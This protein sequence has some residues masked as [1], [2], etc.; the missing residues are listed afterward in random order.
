MQNKL[1]DRGTQSDKLHTHTKKKNT[2]KTFLLNV[3]PQWPL[4]ATAQGIF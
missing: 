2:Q 3:I 1:C 4:K